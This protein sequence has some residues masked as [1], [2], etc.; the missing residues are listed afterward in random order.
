M[1]F[2][3]SRRLSVP[4]DDVIYHH[5][6][7]LFGRRLAHEKFGRR[8]V[9]IIVVIFGVFN[10]NKAKLILVTGI[11]ALSQRV[12]FLCFFLFFTISSPVPPLFIPLSSYQNTNICFFTEKWQLVNYK[13]RKSILPCDINSFG[14]VAHLNQYRQPD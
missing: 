14:F 7:P 2:I 3:C 11:I 12:C 4:T 9:I 1:Y 6:P 13:R 5:L 8:K 10:F